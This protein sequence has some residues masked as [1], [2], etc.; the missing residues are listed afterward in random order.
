VNVGSLAQRPSEALAITGT[1]LN[2]PTGIMPRQ[3]RF[4]G[5]GGLVCEITFPRGCGTVGG[6]LDFG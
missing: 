1:Y 2:P 6:D 3:R 4:R 5:P